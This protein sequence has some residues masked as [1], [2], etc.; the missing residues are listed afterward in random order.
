VNIV[1][2]FVISIHVHDLLLL[3][4]L[5][6]PCFIRNILRFWTEPDQTCLI[7]MRT[8]C[9]RTCLDSSLLL[10]FLLLLTISCVMTFEDYHLYSF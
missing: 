3:L 1:I 10:L 4:R 5:L 7:Y 6:S 8:H 2:I 9:E